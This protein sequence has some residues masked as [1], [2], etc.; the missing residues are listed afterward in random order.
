MFIYNDNLP[1]P[2]P[3]LTRTTLGQL[4]SALWDSRSRPEVIQ[5]GIEPGSVVTPLALRCSALDSCTT[6]LECWEALTEETSEEDVSWS[7][8]G[9]GCKIQCHLNASRQQD[10]SIM[11]AHPA[12]AELSLSRACF[13]SCLPAA[14]WVALAQHRERKRRWGTGEDMEL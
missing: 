9:T 4:C 7:P 6:Q 12:H 14:P 1:R 2:N 8:H 10:E 3:P 5:P 13:P 11:P